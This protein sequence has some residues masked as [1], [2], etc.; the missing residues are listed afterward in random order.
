MCETVSFRSTPLHAA[1]RGSMK[2][3]CYSGI[4]K[5]PDSPDADMHGLI[6][7]AMR[8]VS[9]TTALGKLR[10]AG[11]Q[12]G[13]LVLSG[14]FQESKSHAEQVATAQH[15]DKLLSCPIEKQYTTPDAYRPIPKRLLYEK[16]T[17][18]PTTTRPRSG[19]TPK[20]F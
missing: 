20:G 4:V 12:C 18:T 15:Y 9:M 16:P 2:G 13:G 10:K 3:T 7:L 11:I 19:V 6:R 14:I 5:L 1:L 8:E 17:T